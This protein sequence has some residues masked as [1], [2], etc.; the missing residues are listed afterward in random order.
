MHSF[1]ILPLLPNFPKQLIVIKHFTATE[2]F[3]PSTDFLIIATDSVE[4]ISTDGGGD[5]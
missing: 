2:K 4:V 5:K 1:T 3:N